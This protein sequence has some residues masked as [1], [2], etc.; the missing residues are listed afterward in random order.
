MEMNDIAVRPARR[1]VFI[2]DDLV[3][4]YGSTIPKGPNPVARRA[5]VLRAPSPAK[6]I[7]PGE[8][9]EIKFPD[10]IEPDAEYVTEPRTDAPIVRKLKQT[11]M[12]MAP[13]KC[14]FKRCQQNTYH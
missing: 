8:Y 3:Y 2:S 1:E 10:D 7:W 11:I 13:P 9:L 12:D 4:K 6:T 5:F 14:S